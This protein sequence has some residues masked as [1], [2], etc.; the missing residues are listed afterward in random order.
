MV[1][2]VIMV[3]GMRLITFSLFGDNPLYC[4]GAVEN[5]RIAKEIYPGWT[6]RFYV[7]QDVPEIYLDS[8]REHGGDIVHCEKKNSYDGLNWRFKPLNDPDV[9]YWISR[10][11]DSRLSY[12]EKNAVDEWIASGKSAHLLRDCHNHGYTIMAGMFGINNKVFHAKHGL[13]D[14]ENVNANYREADQTLL[15][16]KLWPLIKYDHVCHDHWRHSKVEGS[17]TYQ[18]GDHVHWKEAYG[19]VGLINYLERDVFNQLREIYPP[20]QD[21]RPFPSHEPME[22]GIF[23]GQIIEADG[24]PR[25]NI[26]VR[27]EYEIRGISYD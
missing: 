7:A 21:T 3:L 2:I 27:W 18:V 26:D 5:A 15:H 24:K 16:D 8:I 14:L 22:Y 12:R 25:M 23:V 11:T 19:G 9:D 13:I 6:A 4:V 1:L 10:D 17:P 20:E